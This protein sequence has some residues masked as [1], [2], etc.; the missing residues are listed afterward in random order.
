MNV[1]S[2]RSP[3]GFA[4]AV[5]LALSLFS[6][7][8]A[9][10]SDTT[11]VARIS[12]IEKGSLVVQRGDDKT[13]VAAT[14]NAPLLPADFVAT[15]PGTQAEIQLDGFIMLRL[16]ANVQARLA[17]NDSTERDVQ[18]AQGTIV[19][20]IV[21]AE[22]GV[23]EIET[24]SV[25]L[26]ATEIGDY[27]VTVSS[28]GSTAITAR[29]GKAEVV[30]PQQTYSL[31]PGQTLIASG[32]AETPA[33]SY[34]AEVA[35]DALDRFSASRD[36]IVN[37]SLNTD[38][39]VPAGIAGYDD[40][41][42]Y[43]QWI[44]VA[45]YG[46]VWSPYAATTWAPYRNGTWV[47]EGGFGWTWVA[48]EPW[49]WAPF[50]YGRWFACAP[51]GWCWY[52]PGLAIAPVWYPALVGFFGFGDYADVT[53]GFDYW[54]W[55]PLAPYEPFYPWYPGW[56]AWH[57][58]PHPGSARFVPRP[59]PPVHLRSAPGAHANVTYTNLRNGAT[60]VRGAAF[61]AGNFSEARTIDPNQLRNIVAIRGTLPITPTT[62]NLSFTNTGPAPHVQFSREFTQPRFA[63]AAGVPLRTQFDA[64][65]RDVHQSLRA[66]PPAAVPPESPGS[67]ADA[68]KRFE[69]ARPPVTSPSIPQPRQYPITTPGEP[70]T[71][72][73][74][75]PVAPPPRPPQSP[76][77]SPP[78]PPAQSGSR[79]PSV[80][81]LNRFSGR[82]DSLRIVGA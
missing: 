33:V 72:M 50:H 74:Q 41:N 28:D 27:R 39:Y 79:P 49:G 52:P 3:I 26:R 14:V 56:A 7:L 32:S 75:R 13:Q 35:L 4:I 46:E 57:S 81:L 55:V 36:H 1:R 30:T 6:A 9:A 11:D 45:P 54:G 70:P 40:L 17:N 63:T 34:T 21:H 66:A 12:V 2:P 64:Q 42:S 37:A 61:R 80:V 10:A 47:W 18:L 73:P 8:P 22:S 20:G 31:A 65:R 25:T 43:G 60:G 82:E 68:W 5:A 77:Q 29:S 19:L 67:T 53:I 44:N 38:T 51:Y 62:A 23:V 24:P 16:G 59:L 58:H 48:N 69:S 15:Q 71:R 76:P 78:R